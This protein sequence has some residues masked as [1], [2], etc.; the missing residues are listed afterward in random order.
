MGR[1]GG[2]SRPA[3]FT[4]IVIE[5]DGEIIYNLVSCGNPS[6]PHLVPPGQESNDGHFSA[7]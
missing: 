7:K 4:E 5:P 1:S 6:R 3:P 2:K